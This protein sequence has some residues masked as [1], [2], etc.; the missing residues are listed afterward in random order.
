MKWATESQRALRARFASQICLSV[1]L[2]LSMAVLAGWAF[3]FSLERGFSSVAFTMKAN[4]SLGALFLGISLLNEV[5]FSRI[6]IHRIGRWAA[7]GSAS[8]AI[9]IGLSV[10]TDVMALNLLLLG[11]SRLCLDKKIY[12]FDI[13]ATELLAS[14]SILITLPSFIAYLYADNLHSASNSYLPISLVASIVSLSLAF[15]L[16]FARPARGVMDTLTCNKTGGILFRK[17]MPWGIGAFVLLGFVRIFTRKFSI[18]A[19]EFGVSNLI[20]AGIVIIVAILWYCA[21]LVNRIDEA[22]TRAEMRHQE[23]EEKIILAE[24]KSAVQM[25]REVGALEASNLKS[26]FLVTMSHEIRTPLNGVIGLTGLLLDSGLNDDQTKTA[27]TIKSSADHLLT[28]LND[29][30]DFSK[31][32]AGKLDLEDLPFDL[33]QLIDETKNMLLF[34]AEQKGIGLFVELFPDTPSALVSDPGRLRQILTNLI[35]NAIKF[36]SQGSVL[37]RIR[38][39]SQTDTSAQLFFEI[40]DSGIGISHSGVRKL[41]QAF[42]QADAS[43]T[44]KYGGTGLGLS[45]SKRLVE[46]MNGEIGVLSREGQ[47]SNFWFTIAVKK[48]LAPQL[49][50]GEHREEQGSPLPQLTG[51]ILVVEDNP[52]NQKV[53][54]AMLSKLGF[55]A[56]AVGNGKEALAALHTLPYDLVLMDCL[57]P[58]MDGYE[59]TREMRKSSHPEIRNL[60]VVALT[61]NAVK[62]DDQQCFDAG[63]ND[64]LTKPI[65]RD[66]LSFTIVKWLKKTTPKAA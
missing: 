36:T 4:A 29:I 48:D 18:L 53:A 22:R 23:N 27:K 37:L 1:A 55:A 45:I 49:V 6:R 9:L 32:E 43:T 60:P 14:L 51:R 59:A 21:R 57:M 24:R 7:T 28:L 19:V 2:G 42:S 13:Y 35:G 50:L 33:A 3:G 25:L 20:V 31:I 16:L 52:V 64:Y 41:F 62:G 15:S 46:M 39:L 11:F 47:G 63:M 8:L 12:R 44:R 26:E 38:A 58:E 66:V 65:K 5:F 56:D 61:A 30:L 10:V 40:R 54:L 17:M 34:A